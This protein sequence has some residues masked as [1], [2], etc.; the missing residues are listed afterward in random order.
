MEIAKVVDI[1]RST[2]YKVLT[3]IGDALSV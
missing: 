2:V 3:T 1:V